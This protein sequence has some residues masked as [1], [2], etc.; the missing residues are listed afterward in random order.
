MTTQ[1]KEHTQQ[2]LYYRTWPAE[3]PKAAVMVIHGLAEHCQ[4]YEHLAERLNQ[5]G[6]S[7]YSM[8]LPGHGRSNGVRGHID[9]FDDFQA[10]ASGLLNSMQTEC[11]DIPKFIIGHSMGG[12]IVSRFL[13]DHQDQFAGALLSGAAI[14]SP[15]EPPAWQVSLIKGIAKLFPK[16]RMLALDAS[17]ISRDK[18]VVDKYMQDPMVGKDKL[19]ARFLVEMTNTMETVKAA[20]NNI[21]LPLLIMHGTADNI[22][23]PS[24][25]ELMHNNCTSVDKTL[26]LYDGLYHEIFNEPEQEKVFD[27]VIQW[28]NKHV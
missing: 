7:L 10:A 9:S 22:T 11:P 24:G 27:D 26:T 14:Q 25:S 8:D 20:A 12:L 23:A 19:T 1:I 17:G 4:R 28:L 5:N 15:Q 6:Y 3:S 13:L 21:S 18:A 16:A 2:G